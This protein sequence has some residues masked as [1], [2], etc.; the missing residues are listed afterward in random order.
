MTRLSTLG[1]RSVIISMIGV[2]VLFGCVQIPLIHYYTFDPDTVGEPP[3]STAP[4]PYVLAIGAFEADVPYQ[5]DK[6][7]FRTPPYEVAFYEYHKW[8]RPLTELASTKVLQQVA[9]AGIFTRVHGQAFQV[10]ADYI[11]IGTISMFDRWDNADS[12]E[13][14]IQ[15]EYQLLD[16]YGERIVWMESIDST[17]PVPDLASVVT[18]VQSFETALHTNIQQALETIHDAVSR[19]P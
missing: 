4:L 17:A 5:Q 9:N 13:V 3:N 6:I 12:S 2:C 1:I 11:L 19:Q 15:I 18:T 7:V 8:L 10:A 16:S 14:R